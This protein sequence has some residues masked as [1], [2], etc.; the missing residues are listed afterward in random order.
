MFDFI[1]HLVEATAQVEFNEGVVGEGH[2]SYNPDQVPK[3]QKKKADVSR[4]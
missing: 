3:E 2:C 4:V 1:P